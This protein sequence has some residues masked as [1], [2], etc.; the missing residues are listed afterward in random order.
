MIY[1]FIFACMNETII[2]WKFSHPLPCSVMDDIKYVL[3][4]IHNY[5]FHQYCD[6]NISFTFYGANS[7]ISM[8]S[9]S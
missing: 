5:F 2:N 7:D 3:F 8:H 4:T 9:I 6:Q 1:H